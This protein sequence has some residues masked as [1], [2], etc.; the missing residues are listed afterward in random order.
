[1]DYYTVLG[2][3]KNA[4]PEQI[5]SAYK[6]LA[7]Q[8]HPDRGGDTNKFSQIN[9]AYDTLKDT[10]K[11]FKYDHQQNAPKN[12]FN[13]HSRNMNEFFNESMRRRQRNNDI[14]LRVNIE[15]IDVATGKDVFATYDLSNGLQQTANVK[16]PPGLQ[17]GDTLRFPGLGDNLN[18]SL[19]RGD[20]YIKVRVLS[21]KK[22]TRENN[23]LK[24]SLKCSIFDLMLGKEFEIKGLLGNNIRLK[25]P[26]G[27][28]PG[29]V[30]SLPGYGLPVANTNKVGNLYVTIDADTPKITDERLLKKVKSLNDEINLRS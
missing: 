9:A 28:N 15:L 24:F 13:V 10:N 6:K 5:K 3:D 7:M 19:Q 20:L 27:T 29:Q 4:S 14:V 16:L 1:M 11:R 12:K 30:L 17:S 8:H 2:V 23:H 21:H 25:V 22:F 18:P 26:A